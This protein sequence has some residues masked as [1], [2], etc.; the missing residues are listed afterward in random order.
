MAIYSLSTSSCHWF[1]LVIVSLMH[2]FSKTEDR[3]NAVYPEVSSV[4]WPDSDM[5][6]INIAVVK[7]LVTLPKY[8]K[9]TFL[10]LTQGDGGW[11]SLPYMPC[12]HN[13][14]Y[15]Q[16]AVNGQNGFLVAS[17]QSKYPKTVV[18]TIQ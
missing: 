11:G 14:D 1:H 13:C 2:G 15:G 16:N 17:K 4:T 18:L 7:N 6:P 5:Q 12:S 10:F 8:L 3:G 9:L